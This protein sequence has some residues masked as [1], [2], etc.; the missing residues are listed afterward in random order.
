MLLYL[1][2]A[3][4]SNEDG[5]NWREEENGEKWMEDQWEKWYSIIYIL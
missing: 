5:E 2:L 1:S 3:M 4:E